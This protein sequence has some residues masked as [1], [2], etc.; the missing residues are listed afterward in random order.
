M[1]GR[2]KSPVPPLAPSAE[3]TTSCRRGSGKDLVGHKL[4]GADLSSQ[5]LNDA[6]S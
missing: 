1:A 6:A 4:D 5:L 2:P 3:H